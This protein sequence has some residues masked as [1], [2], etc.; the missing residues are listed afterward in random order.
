MPE[1]SIKLK[2]ETEN[3]QERVED[4]LNNPDTMLEIHNTLFRYCDPYVPMQTGVLAH[5]VEVTPEHV[6]YTSPYAHYMYEGIVYGPNIPI[7][8]DIGGTKVIVG[9]RSIPGR[10]KTPT[11][12]DIEYN[13]ERHPLADSHWDKRMMDD[14]GDEFVEEVKRIITRRINHG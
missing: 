6:L 13:H 12:K 1:V 4:V 3:L 10:T 11:G 7:Y 14:R 8:Q 9:W 5:T 2:L